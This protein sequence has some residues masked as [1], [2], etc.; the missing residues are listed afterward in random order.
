ML[1]RA[2]QFAKGP[3]TTAER[4]TRGLEQIPDGNAEFQGGCC[5]VPPGA[6]RNTPGVTLAHSGQQKAELLIV[7]CTYGVYSGWTLNPSEKHQL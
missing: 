4:R 5:G 6:Q 3:E 7:T 1:H 2:G